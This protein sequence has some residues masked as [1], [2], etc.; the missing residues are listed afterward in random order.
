V[1]DQRER[2]ARAAGPE[3]RDDH[4]PPHEQPD[5]EHSCLLAGERENRADGRVTGQHRSD[6]ARYLEGWRHRRGHSTA[7]GEQRDRSVERVKKAVM[8]NLVLLEPD[9]AEH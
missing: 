2:E 7:E 6:D 5:A 9:G 3:A 4:V 8:D 1:V